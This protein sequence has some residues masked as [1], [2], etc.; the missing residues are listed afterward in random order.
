MKPEKIISLP[1]LILIF[2]FWGTSVGQAL[3]I[4]PVDGNLLSNGNFENGTMTPVTGISGQSAFA[5]WKQWQQPENRNSILSTRQATNPL[6]EGNYT[7]HISSN[8]RDGIYQYNNGWTGGTYTVSGWFYVL[9]GSAHLGIAWDRGANWVYSPSSSSLNEW[10]F[11]QVT[12][13][14]PACF[15][16]GPLVYAASDSSDF[17]AEGIWFNTGSNNSSPFQP[18]RFDP[19][20]STPVPEPTTMVLLGLG[21]IGVAGLKRKFEK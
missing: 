14:I 11:L 16:G 19:L 7:A 18:D 10:V 12:T 13:S 6:I 4:I 17:Y 5:S 20:Q 21:L 1:T 3:P 9:S 15:N 8:N 2:A